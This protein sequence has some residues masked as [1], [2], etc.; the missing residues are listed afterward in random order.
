MNPK[1]FYERQIDHLENA[2]A[3]N[4]VRSEY[5]AFLKEYLKKDFKNNESENEELEKILTFIEAK[6][7][8]AKVIMYINYL[9]DG[10]TENLSTDDLAQ[11]AKL[12]NT[13]VRKE[14]N[15]IN[16]DYQ[17]NNID[18]E[19]VWWT[20]EIKK[21]SIEHKWWLKFE[22]WKTEN[23][24]YDIVDERVIPRWNNIYTIQ[25][26]RQWSSRTYQFNI[27]YNWDNS[28]T[29]YDQYDRY[30]WRQIIEAKEKTIVRQGRWY[31]EIY[32][33]PWFVTID[34]KDMKIR[35]NIMFK[36]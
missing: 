25:L 11:L 23:R 18:F 35:L 33:T 28:I 5:D 16:N 10:N 26:K 29:I 7:D 27:K 36:R 1:G 2:R 12:K 8:W 9:I 6:N 21:V 30:I 15:N 24:L 14:I 22:K 4:E 17:R 19:I 32:K 13:L 34:T 20:I 31:T 3:I